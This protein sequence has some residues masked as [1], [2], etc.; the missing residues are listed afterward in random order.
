MFLKYISTAVT[1]SGV[2]EC[3]GFV[4]RRGSKET[5]GVLDVDKEMTWKNCMRRTALLH[6]RL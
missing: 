3:R 2:G 5:R 1:L 6:L 4:R